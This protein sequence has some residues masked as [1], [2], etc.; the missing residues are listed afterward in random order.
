MAQQICFMSWRLFIYS[1]K[2]LLGMID[3][4]HSEADIV[5]YILPYIIDINFKI[6]YK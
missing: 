1:M 3:Q 4:C 6:F 2:I 5:N